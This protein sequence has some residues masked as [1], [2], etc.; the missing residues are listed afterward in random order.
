MLYSYSLTLCTKCI[1]N[2]ARKYP[3]E[4]FSQWAVVLLQKKLEEVLGIL[5]LNEQL[6]NQTV[7][8]VNLKSAGSGEDFKKEERHR[9]HRTR[10]RF[11]LKKDRR[12]ELPPMHTLNGWSDSDKENLT[13][14]RHDAL[15][16]TADPVQPA[17]RSANMFAPDVSGIIV[18]DTENREEELSEI[19]ADEIEATQRELNAKQDLDV[20]E[21]ALDD[22]EMDTESG[23]TQAAEQDNW[24]L[25]SSLQMAVW[26]VFSVN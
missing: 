7:A 13:K 22:D 2:Y 14:I 1:T 19:T 26:K 18:E 8:V 20:V 15:E 12:F 24:S 17:D 23:D 11:K 4:E 9:L 10:H 16:N 21:A 5:N 6:P 25:V 3:V